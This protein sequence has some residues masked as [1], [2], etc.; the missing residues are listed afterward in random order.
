MIPT[1][2]EFPSPLVFVVGTI[3]FINNL[4][5]FLILLKIMRKDYMKKKKNI[6]K[7]IPLRKRGKEDGG[8]TDTKETSWWPFSNSNFINY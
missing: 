1:L 4:Y 7:S 2:H 8:F 6:A 5:I 3:Y